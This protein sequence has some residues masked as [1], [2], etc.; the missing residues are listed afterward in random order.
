MLALRH[1]FQ[2]RNQGLGRADFLFVDQNAAVFH[3]AFLVIFVGD[4][5]RRQVAAVEL[6]AFDQLDLRGDGPSLFD[7]DH[8]VL[9]DLHQGVSQNLPDL[10]IVVAGDGG[11]GLDGLLVLGFDRLGEFFQVFD[12]AVD[13]LLHAAAQRHRVGAGGNEAETFAIHGFGEHGGGRRAV[14]GNVAGLRSGFFDELHAHV[15]ERVF[16]L[17]VFGDGHAVLGHLRGAPTFIEDGVAS[18][19]PQGAADGF[20][21][22]GDP[23]QQALA[24]LFVKT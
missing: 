4:E 23:L 20:R 10:R 9:A 17:D 24:G 22:L 3:D 19:R 6:H 1:L 12:D 8:A 16:E 21:Q 13:R 2:Q 18:A 11:D 5:V 14:T 7:G 15:L